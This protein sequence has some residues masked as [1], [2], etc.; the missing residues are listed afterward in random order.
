MTNSNTQI[1][2]SSKT[3]TTKKNTLRICIQE[4]C[5]THLEEEVIVNNRANITLIFFFFIYLNT[6]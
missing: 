4:N 6:L 5:T 3:K 1:Y 2:V